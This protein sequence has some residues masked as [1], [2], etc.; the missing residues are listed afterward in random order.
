EFSE[1]DDELLLNYYLNSK[2]DDFSRNRFL[3]NKILQ[4][5]LWSLWTIIKENEGENFGTYGIDR[6][7]RGLA[8]LEKLKNII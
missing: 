5:I 3:M 2:V 6:Y 4:D 8:N 7:K 1:K